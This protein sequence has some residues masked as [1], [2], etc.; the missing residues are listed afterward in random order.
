MPCLHLLISGRV[1]GVW[2]RE[3]MRQQALKLDVTG[4][5]RNLVDG[6]VEATV[7]GDDAAL[8][9]M[10]EWARRGPPLARVTGVEQ[11]EAPEMRFDGFEKKS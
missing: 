9:R 8:E 2:F 11:G 7:C 10:L 1:Q 3:S 5:V 4:W 6:R